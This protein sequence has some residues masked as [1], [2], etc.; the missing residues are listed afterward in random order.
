MRFTT[1]ALAATLT[2]GAAYAETVEPANVVFTEDGAVEMSLSG[3]AGSVEEGI[4]VYSSR[5]KGNCVAC[6]VVSS[7][8]DVAFP[9]NIGPALDGVAD[10]WN[11]AELRGIVS[12]AKLTYDGTMMP[13]YYKV[14]GFDRPGNAYTGK[15]A[16]GALDPLL[17]AQQI[18]DVVAFLM[19][20]KDE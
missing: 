8:P 10:R 2:A 17:S 16:E 18:E 7:L 20:L 15:A 1:L 14:E 12:N 11:E 19:T 5:S 13:S 4:G 9:G 6:H 3:V